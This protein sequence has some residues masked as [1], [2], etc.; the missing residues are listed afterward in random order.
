MRGAL[1]CFFFML[2]LDKPDFSDDPKVGGPQTL[3]VEEYRT[4]LEKRKSPPPQ[5]PTRGGRLAKCLAKIR[6]LTRIVAVTDGP[7]Q[8][9]ELVASK[10]AE[11]IRDGIA[12]VERT[13]YSLNQR[14][15]FPKSC[16]GYSPRRLLCKLEIYSTIYT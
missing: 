6:D 9:N 15:L 14:L 1:C 4:R 7:I 12:S 8:K 16:Y 10:E 5:K 2:F 3:T 11:K 13:Y